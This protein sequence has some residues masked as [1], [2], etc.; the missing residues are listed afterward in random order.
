[1][2]RIVALFVVAMCIVSIGISHTFAQRLY[3]EANQIHININDTIHVQLVAEWLESLDQVRIA[4]IDAF[5]VL[6]QSQ[7]T[8]MQ[9]IDWKLQ[10]SHTLAF[11]LQWNE[12]WTFVLGPAMITVAGDVLLSNTIELT[13]QWQKLFVGEAPV[14]WMTQIQDNQFEILQPWEKTWWLSLILWIVILVLLFFGVVY[15]L[16]T[17]IP[18]ITYVLK[19]LTDNTQEKRDTSHQA[20][21]QDQLHLDET[22][23]YEDIFVRIRQYILWFIDGDWAQFKHIS[24]VTISDLKSLLEK[25]DANLDERVETC[26][27]IVTLLEEWLYIWKP[28]NYRYVQELLDSLPLQNE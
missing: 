6:S 14:W 11:T 4:W 9:S 26:Q 12:Q 17:Y 1:M 24:W 7:S 5:T 3:L 21:A 8:I 20:V 25:S 23:S 27:K 28:I 15:L 10:S 2:R 18:T 13:I 22:S 16:K 19:N